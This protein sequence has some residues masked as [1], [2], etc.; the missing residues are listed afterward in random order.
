MGPS[1]SI[2]PLWVKGDIGGRLDEVCFTP[3]NGHPQA[4][5]AFP[6]SAK[7]G[8]RRAI[9]RVAKEGALF[10]DVYAQQS[11]TAGRSSFILGEH[12]RAYGGSTFVLICGG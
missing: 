2:R 1:V 9:D 5:P 7:P 6:L 10:T 12:L 3:K 4:V 8:S 11:C